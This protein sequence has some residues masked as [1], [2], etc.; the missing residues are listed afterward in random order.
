MYGNGSSYML[1]VYLLK[2]MRLYEVI[3]RIKTIHWM[4]E[5]TII[6]GC[7]DKLKGV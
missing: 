5:P 3:L 2:E 4:V 6:K 1:K 7:G